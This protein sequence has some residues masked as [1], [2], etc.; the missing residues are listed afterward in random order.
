[1]KKEEK[2]VGR[3]G[4]ERKDERA[5]EVKSPNEIGSIMKKE[6]RRERET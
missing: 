2:K 5:Q 6:E 1:M 4:D 3:S